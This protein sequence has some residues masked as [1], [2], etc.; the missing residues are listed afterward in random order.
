LV[1]LFQIPESGASAVCGIPVS[2]RSTLM[3]STLSGEIP[4]WYSLHL[5]AQETASVGQLLKGL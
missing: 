4:R 2:K 5:I 1:F 3:F